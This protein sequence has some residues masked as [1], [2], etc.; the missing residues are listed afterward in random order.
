MARRKSKGRL[1]MSNHDSLEIFLECVKSLQK[2]RL[3]ANGLTQFQF[4]IEFDKDSQRLVCELQEADQEDF[5]S[6]LLTFRKFI[7]NDEPVN[8]DSVLNIC[9]RFVRAEERE[10]KEVL[11]EIKVVWG[12]AYRRGFVQMQRG[13]LNLT[14]QYV[15]DLW[16]N[17]HYFHSDPDKGQK[18]NELMAD[19]LPS[20]KIQLLWSLPILTRII[21]RLGAVISR[22]LEE[23]LFDFSNDIP[24]I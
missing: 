24:Q 7:L 20:I 18:L 11:D 23:K 1:N 14:P 22:A 12:Y 2:R 9:R 16:V 15:L 8:V 3:V 21:L 19:D 6:F 13:S 17:G 10:L 4:H 5:R